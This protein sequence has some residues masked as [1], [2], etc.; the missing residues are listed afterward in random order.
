MARHTVFVGADQ[1]LRPDALGPVRVDIR[2]PQRKSW[3]DIDRPSA[4]GNIIYA[5]GRLAD[6]DAGQLGQIDHIKAIALAYETDWDLVR[7]IF[8]GSG[9]PELL[10]P[11][12]VLRVPKGNRIARIE[13]VTPSPSTRLYDNAL[14]S[15][16]P[17]PGCYGW[18]VDNATKQFYNGSANPLQNWAWHRIGSGPGFWQQAVPTTAPG[19]LLAGYSLDGDG[20]AF[21]RSSDGSPDGLWSFADYAESGAIG[22]RNPSALPLTGLAYV[23]GL[24][25]DAHGNAGDATTPAV[26]RYSRYW[27]NGKLRFGALSSLFYGRL[28]L[29]LFDEDPGPDY[30]ARL[31]P[32]RQITF[33]YI[34][35][36]AGAAYPDQP[37]I[38]VPLFNA[39]RAEFLFD[40]TGPGNLYVNFYS[41]APNDQIDDLLGVPDADPS[42][43][44]P[45]YTVPGGAIPNPGQAAIVLDPTIHPF[46]KIILGAAAGGAVIATGAVLTIHRS[47]TQ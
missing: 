46:G 33:G 31:A 45:F 38:T 14:A 47:V 18:A 43:V 25:F 29:D 19:A 41:P 8:A 4:G 24:P 35:V 10:G 21:A 27:A 28:A 26:I 30:I 44:P 11:G 6:V 37:L 32:Q 36:A 34:S 22:W 40:N 7:V 9:D 12:R 23:S 39:R 2:G 5:S 13:P 17:Q 16:A 20:T 42:L 1:G 3:P 15:G